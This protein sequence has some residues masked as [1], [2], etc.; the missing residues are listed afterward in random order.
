MEATACED[1]NNYCEHHPSKLVQFACFDSRCSKPAQCCVLCIKNDHNKCK[2]EFIILIRE[3]EN[4]VDLVKPENENK[5]FIHKLNEILE[6][7]FYE[8]NKTLNSKKQ[9]FVQALK[10]DQDNQELKV[11]G[12]LEN[13]KKN[14]KVEYDQIGDRILISSKFDTDNETLE[15]SYKLFEKNVEKKILSFIKDFEKLKFGIKGKVNVDDWV[16][17]NNIV[18]EDDPNGLLFTRGPNDTSFNYFCCLY[19]VPLDNACKFKITIQSIYE[20][21]RFLDFGIVTKSKFDEIQNG[22]FINSFASGGISFCGY[23][24]SG[25]LSGKTLTS[26]STDPNGFKPGDHCI[27]EYVPGESIKF[28]NEEDTVNMSKPMN[29][30]NDT[31][32]LFLVLYHPQA[33]CVLECLL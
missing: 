28:Y 9:A 30:F 17:H 3:I 13:V 22:G 5:Y 11:P 24:H 6:L 1:Y 19:T 12:V 14:F 21:D 27:M 16:K 8:L 2:D 23:S 10:V 15:Q 4:K 33:S 31:Y 29:G 26:S 32:Y 7:K 18:I 25:G 20:S